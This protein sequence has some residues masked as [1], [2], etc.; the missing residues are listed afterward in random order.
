VGARRTFGATCRGMD[1][2]ARLVSGHVACTSMATCTFLSLAHGGP[3]RCTGSS[4]RWS[5]RSPSHRVPRSLLRTAPRRLHQAPTRPL[6]TPPKNRRRSPSPT[7]L[8]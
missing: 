6:R 1:R 4:P 5:S 7:S 3:E 2:A 8:G